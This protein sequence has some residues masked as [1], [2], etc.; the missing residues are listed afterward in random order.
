M[1]ISTLTLLEAG[2]ST[3]SGKEFHAAFGQPPIANMPVEYLTPAI[4]DRAIAIQM[5]LSD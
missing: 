5:A 4:E 3:R 2:F 1:R